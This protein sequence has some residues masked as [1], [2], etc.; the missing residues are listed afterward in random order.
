MPDCIPSTFAAKQKSY[1]YER[2]RSI[3]ALSSTD[4]GGLSTPA[5]IIARS[6]A[7]GI[8]PRSERIVQSCH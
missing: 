5:A 4:I 8:L 7:L 3:I 1:G 6:I 2:L